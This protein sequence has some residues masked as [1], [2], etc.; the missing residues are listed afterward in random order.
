MSRSNEAADGGATLLKVG[1]LAKRSGV[2]V[3]TLHHYDSIGLL[4]PSGRSEGGYR[5]YNRA[6]VA[7]LHGIQVLRG[8]GLPLEE[9]GAMLAQDGDGFAVTVARQLAA[10]DRQIERTTRLRDRLAMV[11]A[12]LERDGGEPE[13]TD[14]LDTLHLMAACDQY[15][16][17][18]EV[19]QIFGN[20]QQVEAELHK[21]VEQVRV[22]MEAGVPASDPRVQP[23]AQ[24]WA[25]LMYTWM[26]GDFDLMER[27]GQ[28]YLAE[29]NLRGGKRPGLSMIRYIE[30]AVALR[31]ALLCKYM[32]MDELKAL[33]PVPDADWAA[34]S[35]DALALAAAAPSPQSPA[36]RALLR[37]W[38]ELRQRACRGDPRIDAKLQRAYR[39]EPLLRDTA[40]MQPAA[41]EFL[42]R[43]AAAQPEAEHPPQEI[44]SGA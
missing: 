36:V 30:E 5:L 21:L 27:W 17:P 41:R 10:L 15:F 29:S 37:R 12:K 13:L 6:D 19:R 31:M 20:F 28:M 35:A 34:L 22:L 39:M 26:K 16:S 24:R 38:R 3:R 4:R 40:P 8:M 42:W 9:I 11:Q 7:R 2:T 43:M 23:Y 25:N 33:G 1:E 14:W 32:S 18:A 44:A